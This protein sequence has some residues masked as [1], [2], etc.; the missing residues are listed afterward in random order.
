MLLY[1][2]EVWGGGI[3]KSTWKEFKNVQTHFL[4]MFL[5]VTKQIIYTL[6]LLDTVSLP[7]EITAME[8]VVEYM[9]KG[10]KEPLTSTS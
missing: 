1:R 5:Q 10:S 2:L 6:L 9:L 7:I 3:P 4:T 8:R